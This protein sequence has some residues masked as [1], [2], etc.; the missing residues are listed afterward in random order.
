MHALDIFNLV[1][2]L[3]SLYA[4]V[5]SLCR[6]ASPIRRLRAL[7]D[8]IYR[9]EALLVSM[10]EDMFFNRHSLA[11]VCDARER[12]LWCVTINVCVKNSLM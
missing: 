10:Q 2:A 7:D 6:W 1:T 5:V 8:D 9:V 12:M 11:I 4:L 3:I